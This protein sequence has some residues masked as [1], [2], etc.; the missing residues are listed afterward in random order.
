ML[1]RRPLEIFKC[2]R[3]DSV[4]FLYKKKDFKII[5]IGMRVTWP[6]L[7]VKI[8]KRVQFKRNEWN[9]NKKLRDEYF[10]Y[11]EHKKTIT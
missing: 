7:N 2:R 1:K 9:T 8:C 5:R 6:Y 10:L 11:I 4:R 3:L